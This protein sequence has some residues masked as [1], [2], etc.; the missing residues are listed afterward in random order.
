MKEKLRSNVKQI[1]A[2]EALL[3]TKNIGLILAADR[4]LDAW[5]DPSFSAQIKGFNFRSSLVQGGMC[6]TTNDVFRSNPLLSITDEKVFIKKRG[7]A[8]RQVR[9][10]SKTANTERKVQRNIYKK[11]NMVESIET[12]MKKRQKS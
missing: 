10:M 11:T 7:V 8:S 6:S 12:I 3:S 5:L 1:D 2:F 9:N 4:R